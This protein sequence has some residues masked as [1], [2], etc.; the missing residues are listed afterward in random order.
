MTK[1]PYVVLGLSPT[2]N[3][4]E[5]RKAFRVKAFKLHPD[6]S[7]LEDI[8]AN[9]QFTE[10]YDAYEFLA[11]RLRAQQPSMTRPK[12]ITSG[13]GTI[14]VLYPNSISEEDVICFMQ[15]YIDFGL[16]T[17]E[18]YNLETFVDIEGLVFESDYEDQETLER[19]FK[20]F[21]ES[22]HVKIEKLSTRV[23]IIED[24][25]VPKRLPM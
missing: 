2:A 11:G 20:S 15:D 6:Q 9:E 24:L 10:L 23:Y 7:T 14:G 17:R 3:L 25:P 22:R 1:D 5:V 12:G 4:A 8:E 18:I 13:G 16:N 21:A 19:T